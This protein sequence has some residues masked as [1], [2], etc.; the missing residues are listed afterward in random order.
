MIFNFLLMVTISSVFLMKDLTPNTQFSRWAYFI[1]PV[2]T[3]FWWAHYLMPMDGLFSNVIILSIYPMVPTFV[4]LILYERLNQLGKFQKQLVY[5]VSFG[6][7][8][9]CF[10]NLISIFFLKVSFFNE[11]F[12]FIMSTL[13]F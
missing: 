6:Y 13:L 3:I 4:F 9:L 10:L 7:W 2:A 12:L 8:S 5:A 11:L 1:A